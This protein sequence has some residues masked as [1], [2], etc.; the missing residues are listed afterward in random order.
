MTS[1]LRGDAHLRW[2]AILQAFCSRLLLFVRLPVFQRMAKIYILITFD[3]L[4]YTVFGASGVVYHAR[5]TGL[6]SI[7]PLF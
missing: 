7:I 6:L 4:F 5:K 2:S 3:V 1:R